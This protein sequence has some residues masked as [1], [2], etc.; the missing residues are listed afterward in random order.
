MENEAFIRCEGLVKIYKISNL[1]I[2]ALQG[3]DIVIERGELMGIVGA[4]GSGKSTL[5]NI[6]GGL[7]RPSAGRVWVD[8]I[9]L[10]KIKPAALDRYRSTRVGFVWQQGARNLIPYLTALE[11]VRLPIILA[12]GGQRQ[13][14]KRAEELLERVDLSQRRHHRLVEMSG[15]EQQRVA[16]AVALANY[17]VLL[18]ADEP[19]GEIDTATAAGIYQLFHELNR[20]GGLTTVI[21]SHDQAISRHVDRVVAIRDGRTSSETVRQPAS[22]A[23][24][25]ALEGAPAGE[26]PHGEMLYEEVVLVDSAGRLQ[27]PHDY[28]ERLKIQGRAKVELTEDGILIV[29]AKSN[30]GNNGLSEA[31]VPTEIQRQAASEAQHGP[32]AWLNRLSRGGRRQ[33]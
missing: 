14:Q 9:D 8:G 26:H 12:G 24:E 21:V 30:G 22:P 33:P 27:I 5:M 28:L 11:N 17:P 20:E 18:L 23:A 13:S 19:T 25:G 15:G 1:E 2:M 6:L 10:L 3:L 7:D 32:R 31:P 4:S 16:I 29:P